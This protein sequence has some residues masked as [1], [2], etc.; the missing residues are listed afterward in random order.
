MV[1]MQRLLVLFL[2]QCFDIDALEASL[3]VEDAVFVKIFI[4]GHQVIAKAL[5]V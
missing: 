3:E 4:V 2:P 5:L 1:V